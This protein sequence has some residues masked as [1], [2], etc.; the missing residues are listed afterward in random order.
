MSGDN[1][2]TETPAGPLS[3]IRVLDLTSVV[4]GPLCTQVLADQG[5]DVILLEPPGGDTNREMGP[6]PHAEFSGVA[7]NLLR[8]K[9]SVKVDLKSPDGAAVARRLVERSDVVVATMR[10]AALERLGMDYPSVRAIRPDIVYCQAQGFPLDG[11]SAN[12]PAY[13]D[14]M[15]AAC[16]VSDVVERIWGE[17]GLLPTIVADKFCGIVMAQAVTAALLHRERTGQGQHVEVPMRQ[18]MGAFMLTEHGSGAIPEPPL[19]VPGKPAAGY[20]RILTPSRRPH[21]TKDGLVHLFPYLPKHYRALFVEAGVPGA[22]NDPRYQTRRATL[23][24]AESLYQEIRRIG[25]TRTTEQWLTYCRAAG[26]PATAVATIQDLVDELPLA[27]HPLVG[28]YRVIPALARFSETPAALRR[29]APAIGEHT[30]EV[31][32]EI[33]AKD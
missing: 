3:G 22:E 8:N 10:P 31:L 13:D 28:Q 21:P 9:R 33:G 20:P 23:Q 17:P 27:D 24:H 2:G 15:Q 16:G 18:A 32:G 5:A 14:I 30:E 1:G 7:L 26:I 11:P 25:P 4:M 12:E 6:G 29:P 19:N